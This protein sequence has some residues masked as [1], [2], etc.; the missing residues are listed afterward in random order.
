MARRFDRPPRDVLVMLVGRGR[1][2]L[3]APGDERPV[4][5]E[6]GHDRFAPDELRGLLEE[7]FEE[8]KL[9][10]RVALGVDPTLDFLATRRRDASA[11][12]GGSSDLIEELEDR[13][14]DRL[15]LE[16]Q[17][18]GRN[19]ESLQTVYAGPRRELREAAQVVR[20]HGRA[21]IRILNTTAALTAL[22]EALDPSPAGWTS[23]IR[24]FPGKRQSLAVFT[25]GGAV[26]QRQTIASGDLNDAGLASEL[27][28][29]WATVQE[30]LHLPPPPGIVL[31]C[32]DSG[33]ELAAAC[34]R[35]TAVEARLAPHVAFNRATLCRALAAQA[36]RRRGGPE[37]LFRSLLD[38][39]GGGEPARVP[40]L[41]LA[42]AGVALAL[43]AAMLHQ[44]ARG[45]DAEVM[46]LDLRSREAVAK[47]GRNPGKLTELLEDM[48]KNAQVAE[49]F[50]M[51]RVYW[52]DFLGEVPGLMPRE[53]ELE[54]FEG[55]HPF[56]V[57][58]K[59]GE[60][61][62]LPDA[63]VD[64]TLSVPVREGA[65]RIP[66]VPQL[67][68]ALRESALFAR[69]FKH[70]PNASVTVRPDAVE[71]TARVSIRCSRSK[72]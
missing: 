18:V 1:V 57:P 65:T 33:H 49:N 19:S 14:G 11:S 38:E 42:G 22:G 7:Y 31:H 5:L 26:L 20:E 32:G 24:L 3:A 59:D 34:R 4:E 51:D 9:R 43:V 12:K 41:S 58:R 29:M 37:R 72:R 55:T 10:G 48:E 44:T 17:A 8:R 16:E 45:V 46:A 6:A 50:L 39:V 63:F 68:S 35:A 52:A 15:I 30:G 69:H 28:G 23:E 21:R 2:T 61:A 40:V 25:S 53:V 62:R 67:T 27:Y 66:Q 54:R 47:Y 60:T 70:V 56:V 36:G 71:Q 64:L 13:H